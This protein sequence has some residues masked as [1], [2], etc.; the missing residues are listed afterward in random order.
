[1]YTGLKRKP[2]VLSRTD[3]CSRW[4][5]T[6]S[7]TN[8]GVLFVEPSDHVVLTSSCSKALFFKP[9]SHQFYIT[10]LYFE[11]FWFFSLKIMISKYG[12]WKTYQFISIRTSVFLSLMSRSLVSSWLRGASDD[13][14]VYVTGHCSCIGDFY[15]RM[16]LLSKS[17]TPSLTVID[18]CNGGLDNTV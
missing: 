11:T 8:I 2:S 14:G 17:F 1:M 16:S 4:T 7:L 15:Q 5:Y 18:K 3:I 13:S 12:W 10:F 6:G 9:V